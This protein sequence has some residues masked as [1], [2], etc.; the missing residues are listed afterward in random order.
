MKILF[1][2]NKRKLCYRSAEKINLNTSRRC[3]AQSLL[4]FFIIIFSLGCGGSFEPLLDEP[5]SSKDITGFSIL[6]IPGNIQA[7]NISLTV[8]Y[9]TDRTY[10]T[11]TIEITGANVSPASGTAQNFTNPISYTVTAANGSTKT[12]TANVNEASNTA[13]DIT[14]F[15][16][17]GISGTIA[18]NSISLTVPYG[19]GTSNLTP[20]ITITGVNVSPASGTARDFTN[21]IIYTV[22]AADGST[23]TYTATVSVALST[24]KDITGF[25]IVG[26]P[27]AIGANS[28]SLTVPYGTGTSNLTP[29]ITITGASVSPASGA[30][31]D[32][33]SPVTYTVTAADGSTKTYTVTVSEALNTAKDITGFSILGIPGTIGAN[34]ILLTVP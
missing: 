9:G 27:G 6:G 25:S 3:F 10:L 33:T 28:I 23:K 22:T 21:P 34:S 20:T 5:Y 24:A 7:N 32:F 29:T 13:K 15:T 2:I 8:P 26:I 16:I 11:P 18:G 14:G 31:R 4:V 19:T 30:A 17:L 1:N 12:Y